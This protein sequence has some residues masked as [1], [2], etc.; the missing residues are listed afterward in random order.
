MIS[1]KYDPKNKEFNLIF[2]KSGEVVRAVAGDDAA[3]HLEE[4]STIFY[5]L[6]SQGIRFDC[7][8]KINNEREFFK[9][10]KYNMNTKKWDFVF[11]NRDFDRAFKEACKLLKFDEKIFDKQ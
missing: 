11:K 1:L 4:M 3:K 10:H 2:D 5:G 6:E 7:D 8:F 9:V